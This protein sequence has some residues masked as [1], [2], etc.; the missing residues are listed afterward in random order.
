MCD[1][2]SRPQAQRAAAAPK[3]PQVLPPDAARYPA[4]QNP[5]AAPASQS[6]P[7]PPAHPVPP[8]PPAPPDF[9]SPPPPAAPT[10]HHSFSGQELEALDRKA[11]A[12]GLPRTAYIRQISLDGAVKGVDLAP[13]LAH[14]LQLSA[15]LETVRALAERPAPDRWAYE[16]DL[17]RL[18]A[19]L[20]QISA[21]EQAL[22]DR[23][24]WRIERR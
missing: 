15:V 10:V 8:E 7:V 4:P 16:A 5:P 12:V 19:L 11:A 14:T 1:G 3:S 6:P 9:P 23:L 17:D 22:L 21:D 20:E 24:T 18:R 2:L 13:V